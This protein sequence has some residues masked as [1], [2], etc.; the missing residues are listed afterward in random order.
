MIV[1]KATNKDMTCTMGDG[2]YKYILGATMKPTER[3]TAKCGHTGL[4][5]CEYV[6]DCMRYYSLE[7]A[8]IFLAE[9]GGDIAEDGQNTRISCEEL[10]LIKEL[11]TREIAREAMRWMIRHSKRDGWQY[12]GSMAEVGQDIAR[13]ERRGAIAI[14][15]GKDPEVM[16]TY[17]AHLG[18]IQEDDGEI[19]AAVLFTVDGKKIQPNTWYG[20]DKLKEAGIG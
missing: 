3:K 20:L 1:Y 5:A 15:R 9:A 16:G 19:K 18:L 11:D 14:A 8:R 17:G 13:T 2:K 4:H 12:S 10:T 6:M 7:S